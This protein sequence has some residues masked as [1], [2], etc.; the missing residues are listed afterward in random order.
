MTDWVSED[1]EELCELRC[2]HKL[3]LYKKVAVI[4]IVAVAVVLPW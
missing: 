3:G 4:I 1:G 2:G